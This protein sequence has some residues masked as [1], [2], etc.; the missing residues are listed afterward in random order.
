MRTPFLPVSA[1]APFIWHGGDYNPEQW[2]EEL[3][4]IDIDLMQRAHFTVPTIGV[5]AWSALQPEEDRFTF[6]WLDRTLDAMAAASRFVFLATPTAAQPAWMSRAY[7]DILLVDENGCRH[8]HGGRVN[9]CPTSLYYRHFARQIAD[10]LAE[11]YKDHPALIAWHVSNEY[12][13]YCYCEHCARQFRFWLQ[14][15]YGTLDALNSAWWTAFWSHTYTDWDQIEPPLAHGE[16]LIHGLNIDYKRFMSAVQ[17]ECFCLERDAIRAHTPT[18]PITTNMMG[19]FE[20]LNYREWAKEVDVIG[21][22]NY[23][24]PEGPPDRVAFN[25]ALNRGLKDGQP[26]LLVE[27]S[28][29]AQNWAVVNKLKRPGRLRCWSYLAL[30]HGAEGISYFQWRRGRGGCEQFH[31]A[32]VEHHHR[33]EARTFR[34][35]AQFGAELAQLGDKTLGGFTPARVAVLYDWNIRWAIE[36]TIG[37]IQDKRYTQTIEDHYIAFWRQNVPCDVV[38]GDS[39]FDEYKIIV[40]PL[41]YSVTRELAERIEAFV[42]DGGIFVTT[43][44]SGIA[45]E[46][47]LVFPNGY[48]GPLS[49]VLGIWTEEVQAMDDDHVNQI[50][51][52]ETGKNYIA[53]HVCEVIHPTSAEVLATFGDDFFAG[54]PALVMNTFGAGKAYYL[55]TYAS[56]AF[57]GDFYTS[58]LSEQGIASPFSV[59]DKVEIAQ[60]VTNRMHI[61][62]IINHSSVPVEFALP[63][64][65]MFT[66]LLGD[67]PIGGQIRLAADDVL[68]VAEQR[69]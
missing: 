43:C 46:N 26:F 39:N 30:A 33:P 21:F 4:A 16:R 52:K 1:R 64:D 32:I 3:R 15:K 14:K 2:P 61:Y 35:V 55:A 22:D 42:R 38:F 51:M 49:E 58:L 12:G 8:H 5:F 69:V 66:D 41:L 56:E 27:Q 34:E 47:D 11:R 53:R 68:I 10:R 23:P 50:V 44:L 45:D 40:A 65:R 31:G 24:D 7:P 57:L 20:K 18:L 6:E 13:S 29:A 62:F 19:A 36:N 54:S 59:P 37:P 17:L 9:Y 48:P 25:Y 60:R 67:A 28:P 63:A